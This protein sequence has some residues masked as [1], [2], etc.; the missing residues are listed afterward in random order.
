MPL[1]ARADFLQHALGEGGEIHFLLL[2]HAAAA[3]V[4][5][6]LAGLSFSDDEQIGYLLTVVIPDLFLHAVLRVV[7]L[8]PQVFRTKLFLN[9]SGVV[10]VPVGDRDDYDLDRGEPDGE[11]AGEVFDHDA[12]EP[13]RGPGDGP[14][15]QHG[16]V[17]LPVLTDVLAAEP[18]WLDEVDL[19]GGELPFASQHVLGQKVGLG[20]VE[21][22]LNGLLVVGDAGGVERF[23]QL[24]LG[25]RPLGIVGDVLG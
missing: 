24:L 18:D 23:A 14:V 9:L 16:R 21:R 6:V 7:D 3:Y 13:F 25:P 5:G 11:G 4:D 12:H 8:D 2:F 20:T 1:C 22:R 19:D 15:Q 17:S 10:E